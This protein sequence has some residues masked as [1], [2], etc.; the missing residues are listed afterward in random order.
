MS[1]REQGN[2]QTGVAGKGVKDARTGWGWHMRAVGNKERRDP[3]QVWV[4]SRGNGLHKLQ[5]SLK[6]CG[7]RYPSLAELLAQ[8]PADVP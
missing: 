1:R 7:V 3:V 6:A 4:Q 8:S 5:V 2:G